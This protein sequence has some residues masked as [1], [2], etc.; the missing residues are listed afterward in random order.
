M[1]KKDPFHT[2]CPRYF[3][4]EWDKP[5]HACGQS[6]DLVK[7]TTC[8]TNRVDYTPDPNLDDIIEWVMTEYADTWKEL[9]KL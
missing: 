6:S 3:L 5:C 4:H 8:S 7:D 1:L 9:S 2:I